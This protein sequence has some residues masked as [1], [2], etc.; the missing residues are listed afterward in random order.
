[1]SKRNIKIKF[2]DFWE[3]WDHENNFITNVLKKKYNVITS[4]LPEYVFF[5][6]FNKLFDHMEYNN[7]VKIFYTQENICPDFNFC[8][9]GIGFE[10]LEYGDRYIEYPIFLIDKRYGDA[11]RL[12][13][14][15]HKKIDGL[16]TRD[17]CSFVV[18]NGFAD[19]IRQ[20]MFD[21]LSEY[22][23][24]SSGGRYLNN[25]GCPNG[26]SNKI[27]FERKHKFSICFENSSHIG[28]TTEKI[29]EAFAAKT[30][31]IYWGNPNIGK[32]FDK[33]AFIDVNSFG[34]VE[35]AIEL[36]KRI[37]NDDDLYMQMLATPALND[38]CLDIW[39]KKQNELEEFLYHIIDQPYNDAFR[40]NR[41]F[42]GEIYE[43]RYRDMKKYY[44]IAHE[45]YLSQFV[46]RLYRKLKNN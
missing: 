17:F 13:T 21:K 30:I 34:S 27:E 12:M 39:M 14:E 15:K 32:L 24:V 35:E 28:Y 6:N 11:W 4:E 33:R 40:R 45:N 2:V 8:D 23:M 3:H 26:V 29:I 38:D 44:V 7:C 22:R 43:K 1:M 25:I 37:D 36:I 41:V 31:P 18:S 42:W 46:I 9:Y 10:E 19:S 16:Q 5:S 20:T